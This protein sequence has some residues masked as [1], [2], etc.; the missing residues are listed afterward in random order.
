MSVYLYHQEQ[1]IQYCCFLLLIHSMHLSLTLLHSEQPKLS[2]VLAKRFL[3]ILSAV[4]LINPVAHRKAKIVYNFGLDECNRV[5][6]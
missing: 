4:D 2:A 3:A 6:E 1:D 5:N